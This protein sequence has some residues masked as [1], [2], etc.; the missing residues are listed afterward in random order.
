MVFLEYPWHKFPAQ[1]KEMSD[2]RHRTEIEFLRTTNRAYCL[3][4]QFESSTDKN[5]IDDNYLVKN[6]GSYKNDLDSMS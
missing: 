3:L 4:G 5:V 6:S 2:G 1:A